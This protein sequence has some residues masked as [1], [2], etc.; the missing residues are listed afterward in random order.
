MLETI[1]TELGAHVFELRDSIIQNDD[2]IK[3][4]NR[5]F[6]YLQ[7]YRPRISDDRSDRISRIYAI[8]AWALKLANQPKEFVFQFLNLSQH[9]AKTP[10]TLGLYHYVASTVYRGYAEF[11]KAE[12]C[13]QQALEVFGKNSLNSGHTYNCLA[14]SLLRQ[15]KVNQVEQHLDSA[16]R[17]FSAIAFKD[18]H[19]LSAVEKIISIAEG[20]LER[21]T[22]GNYAQF[23]EKAGR[24][25]E[26]LKLA[27]EALA[28]KITAGCDAEVIAY[29][30]M[31]VGEILNK[32][33]RHSEALAIFM[34]SNAIYTR[35]HGEKP[36]ANHLR[37]I[38]GLAE[39]HQ[40]IDRSRERTLAF[41][42]Q[43]IAMAEELGLEENHDFSKRIA[44]L[45]QLC[46]LHYHGLCA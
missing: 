15:N 12:L 26:G 44:A 42:K 27:E 46:P 25:A 13:A 6:L 32:L 18:H 33:N 30:Q 20:P 10:E 2:K 16:I 17:I 31:C 19:Q 34:Q 8:Y 21:R 14:L 5:L 1:E 23:F 7:Y 22:K 39:T 36:H 11:S 4:L 43:A 41:L 9:Y 38:I 45:Q 29:N 40:K 28:E 3:K 37:T 35:I 24:Y